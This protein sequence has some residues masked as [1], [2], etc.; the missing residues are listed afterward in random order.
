M[1]ASFQNTAVLFVYFMA[2]VGGIGVAIAAWAVPL[3]LH[4][5][6]KALLK[7]AANGDAGGSGS[8]RRDGGA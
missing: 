4:R 8:A 2:A 6:H 7:I 5:I 3:E 1:L